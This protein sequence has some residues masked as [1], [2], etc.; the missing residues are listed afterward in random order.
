MMVSLAVSFNARVFARVIQKNHGNVQ[1]TDRRIV[2]EA[3]YELL[4]NVSKVINIPEC[5]A[6][7]KEP[8]HISIHSRITRNCIWMSNDC[9]MRLEAWRANCNISKNTASIKLVRKKKRGLHLVQ[10]V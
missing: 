1:T 8:P 5:A 10:E 7:M 9:C 6:G 2:T 3:R 4:K